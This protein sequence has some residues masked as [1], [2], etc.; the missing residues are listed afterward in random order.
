MS[1][2]IK[3]KRLTRKKTSKVNND[4]KLQ[5]LAE[6][7]KFD[8]EK[9]EMQ[10]KISRKIKRLLKDLD[11]IYKCNQKKEEKGKLTQKDCQKELDLVDKIN[12]AIAELNESSQKNMEERSDI[13][14]RACEI[15]NDNGGLHT[16]WLHKMKSGIPE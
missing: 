14:T 4:H 1:D 7:C 12:K 3:L 2:Y 16:E 8:E 9:G 10:I 15:F 6:L 5:D 11:S 13:F